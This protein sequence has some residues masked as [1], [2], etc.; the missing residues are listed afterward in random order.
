MDKADIYFKIL[1]DKVLSTRFKRKCSG[2]N[3][4]SLKNT[5]RKCFEITVQLFAYNTISVDQL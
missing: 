1:C 2:R 3:K 5:N 4:R